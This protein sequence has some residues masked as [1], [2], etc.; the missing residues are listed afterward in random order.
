MVV[1][2]VERVVVELVEILATQVQ[3]VEQG[4]VVLVR[5]AQLEVEEHLH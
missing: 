5:L 2:L 3:V 4:K 1:V